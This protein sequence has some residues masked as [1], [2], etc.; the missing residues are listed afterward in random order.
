MIARQTAPT[1]R[2]AIHIAPRTD[3]GATARPAETT[4]GFAALLAPGRVS[5]G[6]GLTHN[7]SR[8]PTTGANAGDA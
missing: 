6:T 2:P 3:Q 1:A 8:F 7:S 5:A 4:V